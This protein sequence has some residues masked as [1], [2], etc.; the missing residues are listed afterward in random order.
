MTAVS[1][2]MFITGM[3]R[4]ERFGGIRTSFIFQS[5]DMMAADSIRQVTLAR[6]IWSAPDLEREG[7]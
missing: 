1:I 6:W 2:G 7:R 4:N 5:T 3:E